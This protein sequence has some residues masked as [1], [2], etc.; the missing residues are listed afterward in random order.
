MDTDGHRIILTHSLGLNRS[1]V[2]YRNHFA[3]EPGSGDYGVCCELVERGLMV[4]ARMPTTDQPLKTF[5]VTEA[6]KDWL[7]R[8]GQW[9]S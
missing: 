1:K 3:A 2:A 4:V 6:G 7:A 9:P 5:A 8:V